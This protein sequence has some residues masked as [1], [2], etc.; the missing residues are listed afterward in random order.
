M[1]S[2]VSDIESVLNRL[3]S[4][5]NGD[6]IEFDRVVSSARD[7]IIEDDN[8]RSIWDERLLARA[9]NLLTQVLGDIAEYDLIGLRTHLV[10][11][12]NLH[13]KLY[14]V[15]DAT[16][17]LESLLQILLLNW[18][19]PIEMLEVTF[20]S[21][22]K[23]LLHKARISGS[24]DE[25]LRNFFEKFLA[26]LRS[27]GLSV[28]SEQIESLT[29]FGIEAYTR[30]QVWPAYALFSVGG[31][32]DI[33]GLKINA[34]TAGTGVIKEV[35]DTSSLMHTAARKVFLHYQS[36]SLAAKQWDI[37]WEISRSDIQYDGES[38]GL[39]LYAAILV[40]VDRLKIDSYTAFTG[41]VETDGSICRIEHLDAKLAAAHKLGI[42]RVF[43]P[44]E[45][46]EKLTEY[47][48]L[49]IIPVR[50]IED[51]LHKLNSESYER[52]S[53]DSKVLAESKI[54]Q[55][56]ISL[57]AKSVHKVKQVDQNETCIRVEFSNRV[58]QVFVMVY[59]GQNLKAVVQGKQSNIKNIV[60][61]VCDSVFGKTLSQPSQVG[62]A[63]MKR[64]KY[65]INDTSLQEEIAAH[66]LRNRDAIK[67]AE[68][69][70][71]YRIKIAQSGQTVYIR[72]FTNGTLTVEGPSPAAEEII[73]DINAIAGVAQNAEE[74]SATKSHLEEQLQAVQDLE[75]GDVWIGTDESGK[76]D[77]FGPLVTAAV[78]VD[79][80]LATKL[81]NLGIKDSKSLSD[82][83]NIELAGLIRQLCGKRAQTITIPPERYNALYDQFKREGKNLNTLL[84]WGH[85]RVL[86]NI[87]TEFPQEEIT[88]VVDRFGDEHYVENKLLD[89]GRQTKLRLIQLPKA[90]ANIA[91]AAASVLARAQ[92]LSFLASLS[93][94]YG[95]TFPKGASDPKILQVGRDL[96]NKY[97]YDELRKIAK[98][99]F[100]TTRSLHSE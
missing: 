55:L 76:G 62:P 53:T 81:A 18:P 92:F 99:H 93:D 82:K 98:V 14:A 70:C 51:M 26:I 56:E 59:H 30:L 77:Y 45:N 89:R 38:I 25:R 42:R 9:D 2:L 39:G 41:K 72:Q 88:V 21:E 33:Y 20:T 58:D 16:I 73:A 34:P 61:E 85:T 48:G 91:V 12:R 97:G 44:V 17:D 19:S 87:L 36:R 75:L 57:K 6:P 22:E 37:I 94:H 13:E 69:N 96:I 50:S 31:D 5:R 60:Q 84:A 100:N 46:S 11:V 47:E 40:T 23:A 74:H 8:F 66:L 27:Q 10:D 90:E 83:R 28:T 80:S 43:I 3:R 7:L 32:G 24:G 86:E 68:N 63:T 71:I 79:R 15:L 64:Q 65:L 78:L 54:Q 1:G 35:N 52:E 29:N 95:V 67:Q 49:K 4:L